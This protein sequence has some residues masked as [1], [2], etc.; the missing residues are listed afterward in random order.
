[1]KKNHTKYIFCLLLL[2]AITSCLKDEP[3]KL[4]Y[5][6]FQPQN[7]ND[8]W[9]ISSPENEI[10]KRTLIEDAY[11]LLYEDDRF[12]MARSLLIIRNGKLVAEAYPHN[13]NDIDQIQNLQSITKSFTSILTGIALKNN[14]LDSV[15]QTLY[16]IYP[17]MFANHSDKMNITIENTLTMKAGIDFNNNDITEELYHTEGSSVDY[18]LSLPKN[19]EPGIVFNYND[20][21]PHLISAA[22][23][24][25]CGKS[26]SAFANE[27]LFQPLGITDW[28]WEEA[29]DGVTF[30]AFSLYLKPRDAAKFGKLLVQSGKWNS[31]Q[32][33]DSNWIVA[34]TQPL[35]NASETSA[36]YGYYFW[37]YPAYHGYA[38]LGHG[39]QVIFVV[40]DKNL[41]VVYT[42]W[43]YTSGDYFD[44]FNELADLIV[45]S[46][47]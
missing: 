39:G 38:A 13:P 14:I 6:G 16:S 46:C 29:K 7:R 4:S 32:L 34:T 44:N 28:K 11:K 31:Q 17:D 3:F 9:N 19:Y 35:V 12:T 23:Q 36:S 15:S 2:L 24:Q 20:G 42:A 43:G 45:A 18:I 30:G 37:V 27:E 26:L 10:M 22:I 25:R 8:G 40:P 5:S 47:E 33:V 1:M 41:V 21:A